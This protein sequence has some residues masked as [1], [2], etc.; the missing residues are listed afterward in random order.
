MLCAITDDGTTATFKWQKSYAQINNSSAPLLARIGGVAYVYVGSSDGRLYQIEAD[1]PT[2][3]K[4]IPL[5]GP[6][7]T[8]GAPA[9]DVFGNMIYV[10]SDA[11]VI[12]AVQ[13]PIP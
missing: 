9:F 10:G 11:G 2:A 12:Y 7:V 3:V 13:A 5:A 6:S 4:S 8:I 1:S